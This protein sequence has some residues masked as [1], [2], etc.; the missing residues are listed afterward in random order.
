M[1]I[2]LA[3]NNA[4]KVREFN[5]LL[6]PVHL[7]LIP[8]SLL[9][10]KDIE[11][12]GVTFV[13][14][15]LIKARHAA[16]ITGLPALADDS[17]LVVD[18]LNGAPGIYSARFSGA[19]A[20]AKDN[21]EKLLQELKPIPDEKRTASFHCFLVFMS[22]ATDPIPLICHGQWSGIILR[23]PEG[24]SGFGYDPIFYV[25]SEKKSAAALPLTIK[26]KL[27]HRGMAL[28]EL[29]SLLPGKLASR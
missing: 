8:Q 4:G 18:A 23:E 22:S 6:K 28:Q 27:S 16:S 15:A 7:E 1:Q 14:N 13:E 2:V 12:T 10:V 20:S 26:N 3:S 24:H 9:G 19:K 11:E 25:P 5:D 17:G 21:I 29:I